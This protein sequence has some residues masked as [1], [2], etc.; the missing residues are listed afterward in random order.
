[1]ITFSNFSHSLRHAPCM[2]NQNPAIRLAR[3]DTEID[4][5][6]ITKS[7]EDFGKPRVSFQCDDLLAPSSSDP[8]MS[9]SLSPRGRMRKENSNQFKK[10]FAHLQ[11]PVNNSYP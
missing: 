2:A 4:E 5:S 10:D 9:P 11:L 8:H 6:S 3:S 1:M 7:N